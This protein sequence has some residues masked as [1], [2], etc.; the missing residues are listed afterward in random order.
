MSSA[1]S[2]T[3]RFFQEKLVMRLAPGRHPALEVRGKV[4]S[5][6]KR[7]EADGTVPATALLR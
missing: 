7:A 3:C 4:C 1:L 2:A 6:C 5:S